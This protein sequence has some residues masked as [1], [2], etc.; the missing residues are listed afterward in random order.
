MEKP[1]LSTTRLWKDPSCPPQGD[2]KTLPAHHT[3]FYPLWQILSEIIKQLLLFFKDISIS[4]S[5]YL[6]VLVN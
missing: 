4:K 2:G 6:P 1:F 5:T 3:F